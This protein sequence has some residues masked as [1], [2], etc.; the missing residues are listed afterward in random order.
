MSR[1]VLREPHPVRA[2]AVLCGGVGAA[3]WLLAFGLQSVT[4]RGYL[5]WTLV[6]G[7]TAWLAAYLL[8][9]TGDRGVATGVA[10]AAGFPGP[11][12]PDLG[13]DAR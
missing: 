9:I 7:L 8:A 6:A 3:V 5:W 1:P 2:G 11:A 4:L 12:Q 13:R 10:A